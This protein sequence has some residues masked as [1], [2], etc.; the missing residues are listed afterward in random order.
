LQSERLNW[1]GVELIFENEE[2]ALSC[3]ACGEKITDPGISVCPSCKGK[4]LEILSGSRVYIKEVIFK[5]D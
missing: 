5:G 2:P 3:T 1:D 4:E